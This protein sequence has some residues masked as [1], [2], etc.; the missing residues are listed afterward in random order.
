[1]R[2][3]TTTLIK[4]IIVLEIIVCYMGFLAVVSYMRSPVRYKAMT[5]SP[6]CQSEDFISFAG[7]PSATNV[8]TFENN[9]QGQLFGWQKQLDLSTLE[10]IHISFSVNCPEEFAG[11][12]LFVDLYNFEENY[13]PSEQEYQ[14]LLTSGENNV[15]FTLCPGSPK[16][17]TADLRFFTLDVAQYSVEKLTVCQEV[18]LPKIPN[19]ML[20]GVGCCFL[21]LILSC[22]VYI[23]SER[24]KE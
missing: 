1:M 3:N 6:I 7:I 4:T 5:D 9:A 13:D 12:T 16:P 8:L 20:P 18:A 21:M 14:L 23:F 17:D 2:R 15:E 11:G 24:K 22:G 19:G 10:R